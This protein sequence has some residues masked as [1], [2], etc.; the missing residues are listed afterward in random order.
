[1]LVF[2]QVLI[3][4]VVIPDNK[5]GKKHSTQCLI[6]YFVACH[7]LV[8]ALCQENKKVTKQWSSLSEIFPGGIQYT[9]FHAMYFIPNLTALQKEMKGQGGL[10]S[11]FAGSLKQGQK[12]SD[13]SV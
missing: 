13:L 11:R 9:L 5:L 3:K 12:V 2:L 4:P 10:S 6:T 8:F 1:M 7:S